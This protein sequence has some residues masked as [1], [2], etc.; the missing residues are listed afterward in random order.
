[1]ELCKYPAAETERCYEIEAIQIP[2][3]YNR[4]GDHDPDGLLYVLKKDADRIRREAVRN[5]QKEIPQPCEDVKPL[6]IRA[7]LGDKVVIHFSHS[8]KRELS[9][10]VQGLAYDVRTSDGADVGYNRNTTTKRQITY[11]WYAQRSPHGPDF[12]YDRYQLPFRTHAQPDA[13]HR[14]SRRYGRRYFHELLGLRR[15]G[16][17]HLKGICGRPI[18]NPSDSWWNQGNPCVPFA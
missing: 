18:E 11:T 12:S 1:M 7:N 10:H 5:F 6:V 8:L 17:A 2:I 15:S 14:R 4:F 3:V 13:A 9:I 16:A